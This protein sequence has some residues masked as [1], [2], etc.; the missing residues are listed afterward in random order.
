[1]IGNNGPHLLARRRDG[2]AELEANAFPRRAVEPPETDP[3]RQRDRRDRGRHAANQPLTG[4]GEPIRRQH[5]QKDAGEYP[6]VIHEDG[7]KRFTATERAA[8]NL[9]QQAGAQCQLQPMR[10]RFAQEN[11]NDAGGCQQGNSGSAGK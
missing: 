7:Q 9:A 3:L 4:G 11:R 5:Q 6:G 8:Q 1:V 10:H 2:T